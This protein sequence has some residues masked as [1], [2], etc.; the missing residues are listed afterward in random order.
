MFQAILGAALGGLGGLFGPKQ[1]NKIDVTRTN[2][3]SETSTETP[4]VDPEMM[5]YMRQALGGYANN[6]NGNDAMFEALRRSG[7]MGINQ[8][9]GV[10]QNHIGNLMASR[11]L[12]FSQAGITPQAYAEMARGGQIAQLN[13]QL[14]IL[15]DQRM[16]DNLGALFSSAR[17]VP[18][19]VTRTG[20]SDQTQTEKGTVPGQT[21]GGGFGGAIGGMASGLAYYGGRNGWF[22]NGNQN[23]PGS[24]SWMLGK[25]G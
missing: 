3:T 5:G 4:N 18:F 7:I 14:P 21:G 10:T 22:G 13:N 15:K 19:S 12:N 23:G 16:M 1:S 25:A 9:A 8:Q 6:L 2:K 17:Q 11:G 24:D 20:N